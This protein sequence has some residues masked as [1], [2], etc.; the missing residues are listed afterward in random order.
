M[1]DGS[2]RG[3]D[4]GRRDADGT[5]PLDDDAVN[6][7]RLG[8]AEQ[9]AHIVRVL[10]EVEK[11]EQRRLMSR[12]CESK[13]LVQRVIRVL[14]R[15]EYHSLVTEVP[16]SIQRTPVRMVDWNFKL[17]GQIKNPVNRLGLPNPLCQR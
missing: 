3:M 5:S 6:A 9:T 1:L 15:L 16:E 17:F 11:K 7:H 10:E 14:A 2:H 13:Q 4:H 8:R 12:L